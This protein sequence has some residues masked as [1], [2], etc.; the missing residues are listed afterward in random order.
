MP[1]LK[2]L[3]L[4]GTRITDAGM[5]SMV[6][7]GALESLGLTG[8][9]ITDAGL[10]TL[11]ESAGLRHLALSFWPLRTKVFAIWPN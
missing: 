10:E 8:T 1:R 2:T 11:S 5:A 4:M 9:Q 3:N 7:M 6:R